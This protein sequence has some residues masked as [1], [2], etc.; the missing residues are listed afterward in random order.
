MEVPQDAKLH[1]D[2]ANQSNVPLLNGS[3]RSFDFVKAC[4]E[5]DPV[6]IDFS[7]TSSFD[8]WNELVCKKFGLE[9]NKF[10]IKYLDDDKEW[11]LVTKGV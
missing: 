3:A 7:L 10:K 1:L 4:Y 9:L 5:G 11:F 6:W 8:R 2:G